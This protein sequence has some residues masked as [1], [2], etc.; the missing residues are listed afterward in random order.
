ME[1]A[2][3]PFVLLAHDPVRRFS[4][5]TLQIGCVQGGMAKF[6]G[7][8]GS[9]GYSKDSRLSSFRWRARISS[10]RSTKARAMLPEGVAGQSTG[11]SGG[12]WT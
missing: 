2:L 7:R 11:S 4:A 9:K 8:P 5:K 10:L 12:K 3:G 6:A 1:F